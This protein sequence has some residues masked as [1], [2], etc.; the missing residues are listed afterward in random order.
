VISPRSLNLLGEHADYNDGVSLPA[1]AG[2]YGTMV[3]EPRGDDR[4]ILCALDLDS[5]AEFSLKE[6]DNKRDL[7]GEPLLDWA[8][9]PYV[10]NR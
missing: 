3:M 1:A 6:I 8:L 7:R 4:I 10:V 2:R 9:Y 5:S